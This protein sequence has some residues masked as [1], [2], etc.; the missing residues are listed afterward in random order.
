MHKVTSWALWLPGA[1][2]CCRQHWVGLETALCVWARSLSSLPHQVGLQA[3]LCT[4][5]LSH[6]LGALPEQGCRLDSAAGRCCRQVP[7][8][9]RVT[10]KIP[11]LC[12]V[13]RRLSQLGRAASL[14]SLLWDELH[15]FGD[16]LIRLPEWAGLESTGF[17]IWRICWPV[18]WT[19]Q[20]SSADRIAGIECKGEVSGW[21]SAH[22]C[23][24]GG[25]GLPRSV[26]W[27][28]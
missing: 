7:R 24:Q 21:L 15:G 20:S 4:A 18:T 6:R 5:W 1:S 10:V 26:C 19:R 22:I 13:E 25:K 28:L 23:L 12:G 2:G 17:N 11:S 14:A 9:S 27:L 3:M 16:S 8:L